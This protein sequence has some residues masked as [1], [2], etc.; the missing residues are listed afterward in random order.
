M[1][2]VR[3]HLLTKG[4]AQ[5]RKLNDLIDGIIWESQKRRKSQG[6]C[7]DEGSLLLTAEDRLSHPQRLSRSARGEIHKGALDEATNLKDRALQ[8]LRQVVAGGLSVNCPRVSALLQAQP[9]AKQLKR[10]GLQTFREIEYNAA[11]GEKHTVEEEPLV[12]TQHI[13]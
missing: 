5:K 3:P 6:E 4:F 2:T 10:L 7:F 12:A 11:R 13:L 1:T 9:L 8:T